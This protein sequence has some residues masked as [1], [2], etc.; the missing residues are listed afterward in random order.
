[1]QPPARYLVPLAASL[2]AT[3]ACADSHDPLLAKRVDAVVDSAI[4]DNR[5][6]GTVVLVLRD[7]QLVYHRAAGLADREDGRP[8]T[9]DTIFRLASVTKPLV[10]AAAMH[11]V[12]QGRLGLDDPVSR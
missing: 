10:S 9:E 3:L 4:A 1:M 8:M 5:L 6:V 2:C 7:G 12:E 11:L